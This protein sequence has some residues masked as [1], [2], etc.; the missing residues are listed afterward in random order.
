MGEML[1]T[2]SYAGARSDEHLIDLYDVSQALIGFQRSLALTTHLL[3]NDQIITQSPS[4]RGAKIYA[5]APESGSWKLTTVISTALF[6]LGTAQG[7]SPVGH[8]LFSLYDYVISASLGINVDYNKS[9]GVLYK[10]AA[11]KN[12]S[13]PVIAEHQ[14]DALIE[15]CTHAIVEMHRPIVKSET[16]THCVI[17]SGPR[18]REE[19][20]RT[21]LN[22]ETYAYIHETIRDRAPNIYE[23]RVSSYNTNT[24]KG[25][26]YVPALGRPIAF[27]L[28][29]HTR[30]NRAVEV[31]A[32][33][34]FHSGLKQY[35]EPGSLIYIVAF[36]NTSK[37]GTLKSFTVSKVS[38]KPYT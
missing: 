16:A 10:E 11:I 3:L 37:S 32:R 18:G 14:A 6:T 28:E 31:I 25:R 38:D 20:L 4:L 1:F 35:Q 29:P 23:G 9:L 2:L 34:L 22:Q 12:R 30:S 13:L 8:L 36:Q 24:F 26:I 17:T 7:N 5:A 33:S 21:D 15:K 19:P 27:E